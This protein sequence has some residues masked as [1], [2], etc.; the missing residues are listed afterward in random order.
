MRIFVFIVLLFV[1]LSLCR[2]DL[3]G[4]DGV[5]KDNFNVTHYLCSTDNGTKVQGSYGEFGIIQAYA[6]S[7]DSA[8]GS[9]YVAWYEYSKYCPFGE[10][11]WRISGGDEIDGVFICND[12]RSPQQKWNL[13]RIIPSDR[14][15]DLDCAILSTSVLGLDGR[16]FEENNINSLD[17]CTN[18][19][20]FRASYD[21]TDGSGGFGYLYGL[22]HEDGKVL[23]GS[24][25]QAESKKGFV[26]TG[27][28]LFILT[29]N[30]T[31]TTYNW[32]NPVTQTDLR[33]NDVTHTTYKGLQEITNLN[34]TNACQR[35]SQLDLEYY[36]TSNISHVENSAGS[37]VAAFLL[38]VGVLA[39]LF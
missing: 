10:F 27:S 35:N 25:V 32:Q 4:I 20:T 26:I 29:T 15:A 30:N 5:W 3:S 23:Q 11:D 33:T 19:N 38:L 17:F 18:G 34:Q 24:Y 6:T 2:W 31:L 39:L 1:A 36:I 9:F 16:S 22:A 13:T 8:H 14:P 12:G 37:L 21:L 28:G 7:K